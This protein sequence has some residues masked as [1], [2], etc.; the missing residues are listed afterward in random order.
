MSASSTSSAILKLGRSRDPRGRRALHVWYSRRILVW[1][2]HWVLVSF[3]LLSLLC[4]L[5]RGLYWNLAMWTLFCK[6]LHKICLV[7]LAGSVPS[8]YREVY[9]IVCP[10]QEEKIEREM[11][12][13]ILM[14]SSLP[15][16]SLTQ[17]CYRTFDS[18]FVSVRKEMINDGEPIKDCGPRL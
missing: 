8:F 2:L 17:V 11:F 13:K 18:L 16:Q 14:K 1:R 5:S 6:R 9:Q 10:N 3:K 4:T 15:K 12:V 7:E